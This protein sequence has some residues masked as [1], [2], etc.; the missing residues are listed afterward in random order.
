MLRERNPG[1]LNA[2]GGPLLVDLAVRPRRPAR[3]RLD[4]RQRR[5]EDGS[6]SSSSLTSRE[7]LGRRRRHRGALRASRLPMPEGRL[8]ARRRAPARPRTPPARHRRSPAPAAGARFPKTRHA[9]HSNTNSSRSA[10][11]PEIETR[12][13]NERPR[14]TSSGATPQRPAPPLPA[15]RRSGP[16]GG[17]PRLPGPARGLPPAAPHQ[18]PEPAPLG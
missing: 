7:A 16:V 15:D 17:P 3:R 1:P 18:A 14:A 10:P 13:C 5:L 4:G 8:P 2:L 9:T 11:I 6:L 12:L